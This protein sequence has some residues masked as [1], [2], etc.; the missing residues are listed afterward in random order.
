MPEAMHIPDG[1]LSPRITLPAW[2]VAGPVWIWAARRGFGPSATGS[3]PVVGSLT[4]LAFVVQ[5]LSVPIPGGTSAHLTGVAILAILEGPAMA[6]ACESLVLL[7]QALFFGTGGFTTLGVNALSMGLLGPGAAGLAWRT[8]RRL[9]PQA[10][11]FAGACVGMQVSTAAL[12]LILGLQHRLDPVYIPVPLEVTAV[13]MMVP[14][15]SLIGVLE[16][17]YTVA[18]FAFLRRAR[19]LDAP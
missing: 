1:F 13:A 16:G 3:L 7:L 19:L 15:L 9:S 8:L 17:L 18:T 14:S 2:G 11:A 5:G 6:F 12:V 10:A 4:A